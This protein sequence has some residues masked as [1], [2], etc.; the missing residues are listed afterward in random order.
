LKQQYFFA[1]ATIQDILRRFKKRNN[2]L[3]V[4]PFTPSQNCFPPFFWFFFFSFNS[5]FF[6][7]FSHWNCFV[8]CFCWVL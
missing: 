1:C 8:F 4:S 5:I 6:L 7:Q 3:H 2:D